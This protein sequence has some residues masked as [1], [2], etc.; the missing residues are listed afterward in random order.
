MYREELPNGLMKASAQS[1]SSSKL[2]KAIS[3]SILRLC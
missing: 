3:G 1:M 2:A